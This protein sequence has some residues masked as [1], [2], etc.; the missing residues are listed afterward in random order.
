[1]SALRLHTVQGMRNSLGLLSNTPERLCV[2]DV[3]T[4][5]EDNAIHRL[6]AFQT[7]IEQWQ[8]LATFVSK[9]VRDCAVLVL[10]LH[11]KEPFHQ[12]TWHLEFYHCG[13]RRIH[14]LMAAQ[15]LL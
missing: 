1:M 12:G 6:T 14:L 2:L 5:D 7:R 4:L 15:I 9:A 13:R 8:T 11:F 10:A 3:K